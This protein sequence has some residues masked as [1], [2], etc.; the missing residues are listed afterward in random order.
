MAA[1]TRRTWATMKT[2]VGKRLGREGDTAGALA[3]GGP[4]EHWIDAA[5]R[6]ICRTWHQPELD[7]EDSGT[8]SGGSVGINL[9]ADC[10]LPIAL[11]LQNALGTDN[12]GR[13]ILNRFSYVIGLSPK[14]TGQPTEFAR[15]DDQIRFDR[16]VDSSYGYILYYY[17]KPTAVDFASGGPLIDQSWDQL[18]VAAATELGLKGYWQPD[19]A[20]VHAETLQS[21][22]ARFGQVM[23]ASGGI[24]D[25]ESAAE[26]HGGPLG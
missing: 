2:E 15:F 7:E 23:V 16:A 20:R 21:W 4:V 14:R 26:P 5:Y 12:V 3:S 22:A 13:V 25:T 10:L 8:L 1:L 24:V 6:M 17:K 9:P 11:I 18:I 19:L